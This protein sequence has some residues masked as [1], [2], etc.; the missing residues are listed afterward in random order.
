MHS[1]IIGS[2]L[3]IPKLEKQTDFK[4]YFELEALKIQMIND[5]KLLGVK[6]DDKLQ[7]NYQ[8]EQVKAK[9]LQALGL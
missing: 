7:W 4:P 1:L 3:N 8:V 9:A 2:K 6:I 5:I